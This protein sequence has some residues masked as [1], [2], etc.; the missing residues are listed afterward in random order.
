[1]A[2]LIAQIV[3]AERE[4]F[5]GEVS[6]V[7]ARSVQGEI[8]ILPGHQPCLLALEIAPCR[9]KLP[10]GSWEVYA[11]HEGFLFF[12]DN[13]LVLLADL[14]EHA[15]EIDVERARQDRR[16]HEGTRRDELDEEA[17][18]ALRRAEVRITVAEGG[19]MPAGSV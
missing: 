4:L 7:Y 14:A 17:T 16:E 8:G 5:S 15:S 6:E 18:K 9:L 11:V 12:R 3:S 2:E 19:G 13:R 1:M 10:D